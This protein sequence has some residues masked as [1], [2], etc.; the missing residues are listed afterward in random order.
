MT[1]NDF[2]SLVGFHCEYLKNQNLGN[3]VFYIKQHVWADAVLKSGC[4]KF[5]NLLT[6]TEMGSV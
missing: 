3:L 6:L 2:Y 4:V 1:E 5:L